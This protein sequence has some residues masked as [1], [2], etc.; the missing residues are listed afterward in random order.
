[1]VGH[2]IVLVDVR[3]YSVALE[4]TDKLYLALSAAGQYLAQMS[5]EGGLHIDHLRM[6]GRGSRMSIL[7]TEVM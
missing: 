4:W 2:M 6:V 5:L 7:P 3:L 1:M